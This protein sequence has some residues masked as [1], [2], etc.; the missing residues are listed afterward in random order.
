MI[1]DKIDSPTDTESPGLPTKAQIP[2]ASGSVADPHEDLP[3]P[4]VGRDGPSASTST[5]PG[6]G[7]PPRAEPPRGNSYLQSVAQQEVNHLYL[8]SKNVAIS[9]SYILNS[10]LSGVEAPGQ[11]RKKAALDRRYRKLFSVGPP[12][13]PTAS[14]QTRHGSITL[15]LATAGQTDALN[16]AHVQ[17]S[18]RH[19]K[20]HVNIYSLQENKHICLEVST[21]HGAIVLFVPPTFAG[22]L[23]LRTRRG[24]IKFL[25]EFERWAR[26]VNASDNGAVVLFGQSVQAPSIDVNDPTADSC[27]LSTRHGKIVIGVSG[28]DQYDEVQ[29]PGLL[30]KLGSLSMLFLGTD[31]TAPLR[32]GM[33]R[34]E[35]LAAMQR[36]Q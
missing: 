16:K 27:L 3:P 26:L 17:V 8:Q 34:L 29:G 14:I 11:C 31:V 32:T 33:N 22:S 10:E 5:R 30:E 9:G 6:S 24:N 18:S 12:Q 13:T 28:V 25:P 23:R 7:P 20:V 4:Y 21:R 15:N 1:I 19:G 35:N 2:T 36:P